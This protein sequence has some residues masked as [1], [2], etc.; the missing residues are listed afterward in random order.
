MNTDDTVAVKFVNKLK[1]QYP[2]LV[3]KN[4]NKTLT[5]LRLK[6]DETEV[7]Q[8]KKKIVLILNSNL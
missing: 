6:K 1:Q 2:W 7:E 3:V 4:L 5:D 8:L